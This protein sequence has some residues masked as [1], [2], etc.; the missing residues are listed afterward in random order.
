[1]WEAF[2]LQNIMFAINNLIKVYV[3]SMVNNNKLW[4]LILLT[5]L[6]SGPNIF[7]C[8]KDN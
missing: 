2:S 5:F 8:V 6:S 3:A 4:N 7:V 1:M